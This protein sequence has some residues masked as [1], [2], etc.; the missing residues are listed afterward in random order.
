MGQEDSHVDNLSDMQEIIQSLV[1][2]LDKTSS[3]LESSQRQVL[4]LKEENAALRQEIRALKDVKKLTL[5]SEL[6]LKY[7]DL[8]KQMA[9]VREQLRYA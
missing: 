4:H 7:K 8:H 2:E 6:E 3:V 9:T 5:I 1:D